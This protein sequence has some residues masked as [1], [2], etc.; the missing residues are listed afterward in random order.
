MLPRLAFAT[1]CT[2]IAL[3]RTPTTYTSVKLVRLSCGCSDVGWRG[4]KTGGESNTTE[5]RGTD[6]DDGA[7]VA[8]CTSAASGEEVGVAV[9]EGNAGQDAVS[10]VRPSTGADPTTGSGP[11]WAKPTQHVDDD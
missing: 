7:G 3:K 11:P 5:N 4:D 6:Q 1:E 10:P 2:S 9:R 8:V